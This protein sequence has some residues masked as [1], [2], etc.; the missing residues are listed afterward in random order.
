MTYTVISVI[1][2]GANACVGAP[3]ANGVP[4]GVG[5]VTGPN[6]FLPNKVAS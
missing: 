6:G 5:L 2:C 1:A 4:V 3:A